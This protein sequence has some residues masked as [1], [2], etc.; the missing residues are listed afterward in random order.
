MSAC[1][2]PADGPRIAVIVPTYR[3]PDEL[4]RC[5]AAI[6]SQRRRPDQLIVVTREGD[7][8]TQPALRHAHQE[9]C[10]LTVVRVQAAGVVAALNAGLASVD[11][12]I[13]AFTDDDA[14]PRRDWLLQIAACFASDPLLGGVGGR[15][16]VHHHGRL[17]DGS[18][19]V[20][21]RLTWYGCCIGHHHLGVGPPR[22]VDALK[23]VNMSFRAL[24]LEGVSFDTRLRGTGAQV[25][26]ELGVS[27]AVKRSGWRLVYD[28]QIAV[29]HYPAAR[30]DEDQRDHFCCEAVQNAAFNETLLLSEHFRGWR[31]AVYVVWAFA[32]GHRA[33]PGLVQ[34][35]RLRFIEPRTATAR[36]RATWSARVQA[37]R[38]AR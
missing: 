34:W 30:H 8:A 18:Q 10:R 20:V 13:V 17:E 19:P 22:E 25:S 33:A 16:W 12:D 37:L 29:D 2:L 6:A 1:A 7:D 21:G 35:L 3:R 23:G 38:A 14:A 32:I 4:K 36:F 28:P 26:N 9:S 11:A 15:D 31:R 24:A 27:L 5:L